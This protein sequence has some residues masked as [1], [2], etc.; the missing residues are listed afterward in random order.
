MSPI[1]GFI[2][3]AIATLAVCIA[4]YFAN[5]YREGKIYQDQLQKLMQ[6]VHTA[7]RNK[8][9]LQAD[10]IRLS[11]ENKRITEDI[12]KANREFDA[13]AYRVKTAGEVADHQ[14]KLELQTRWS[15]AEDEFDAELE[16]LKE[17]HPLAKYQETLG[18][19]IAQ[20]SQSRRIIQVIQDQQKAIDEKEDF[21]KVHSLKLTPM[22]RSDIKLLREISL[23]L[24]R[25]DAV[26]KLIWSEY[27]QRPLQTLRKALEVDKQI[28]IYQIKEKKTGRVYI[29]QA[30]NIGER[31]AEH[32]KAGLG[33]GSTAYQTNKF[34]KAMYENGPESFTFTV[35]EFCT[36]EELNEKEKYWISFYN[37][38]SFGFNTQLG[39]R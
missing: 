15:K 8:L 1:L 36:K 33:I 11:A 38:A 14:I 35:I 25:K 37:A 5:Q 16:K 2:L 24:A 22:E 28:G 6:D 12:D 19:L 9:E 10:N 39:G 32:V 17:T 18:D 27:Y 20:I 34:Y 13:A 23:K 7:E 4:I 3:M 31:W 26:N 30:M 29:G 21:E